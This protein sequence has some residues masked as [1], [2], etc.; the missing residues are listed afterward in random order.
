MRREAENLRSMR[1]VGEVL[2]LLEA[3]GFAVVLG[4]ALA[5]G[6]LANV[7]GG[8]EQLLAVVGVITGFAGV[9]TLVLAFLVATRDPEMS[10]RSRRSWL[11]GLVFFNAIAAPV[12][13]TVRL[14]RRRAR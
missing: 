12:F 14:L 7:S 5:S 11:L 3:L 1:R 2:A 8:R 4:F 9:G 6:G 10:E 13:F